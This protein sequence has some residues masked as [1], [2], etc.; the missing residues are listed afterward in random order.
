MFEEK[1]VVDLEQGSPLVLEEE[2]PFIVV[3][4]DY[5]TT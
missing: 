2:S 5:G 1:E 3:G 4:I